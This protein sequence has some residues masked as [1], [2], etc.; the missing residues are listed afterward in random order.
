MQVE[1]WKALVHSLADSLGQE[2]TEEVLAKVTAGLKALVAQFQ[3][4]DFD[5]IRSY[6]LMSIPLTGFFALLSSPSNPLIEGVTKILHYLL[7]PESYH[8]LD[9]DFSDYLTEGLQ[10][11]NPSVQLLALEQ[12]RKY[13]SSEGPFGGKY[14]PWI[15]LLLS[16]QNV[17]VVRASEDV[18]VN[19]AQTPDNLHLVFATENQEAMAPMMK[20]STIRFR[21]YDLFVGISLASPEALEICSHYGI[22]GELCAEAQSP[23]LLRRLSALDIYQ[24]LAHSPEGFAYMQSKFVFSPYL[25]LMSKE[26]ESSD[27]QITLVSCS[28]IEFFAKFIDYQHVDFAEFQAE[29]LLFD[30]MG[31]LLNSDNSDIKSSAVMALGHIGSQPRG[32][33][34][35]AQHPS[36]LLDRLAEEYNDAWQKYT[37]ACLQAIALIFEAGNDNS[38]E[39]AQITEQF[40][41]RIDKSRALGE[42]V[43]YAKQDTA[44]ASPFCL[45]L[46]TAMAGYTWG[47]KEMLAN[48]L[49][50]AY[51]FNRSANRAHD[52]KVQKH[53][54]V[55]RLYMMDHAHPVFDE[56][57]HQVLARYIKDGAFYIPAEAA[58]ASQ[59]SQ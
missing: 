29:T 37:L 38:L 48:H 35:V 27:I 23:D 13:K 2:P 16:S 1:P 41:S 33:S 11:P 21:V 30:V 55:E 54:L 20:D 4:P 25:D 31:K 32:L 18:L 5:S 7:R 3:S 36:H 39:I 53:Q 28:T 45:R 43:K 6:T 59:S 47:R 40:Y 56:N 58:V 24:K 15:L 42:W 49:F 34:L 19:V 44:D 51:L 17:D 8:A 9:K 10:H 50:M 57:V 26:T 12:L 52:R 22:L 46:L 14:I